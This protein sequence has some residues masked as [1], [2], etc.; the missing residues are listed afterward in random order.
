MRALL[1]LL[2]SIRHQNCLVL[3]PQAG[4][5]LEYVRSPELDFIYQRV[6]AADA[7]RGCFSE[8][9]TACGG[10]RVNV[11]AFS[12][13]WSQGCFPATSMKPAFHLCSV[14]PLQHWLLLMISWELSALHICMHAA[15]LSVLW[16]VKKKKKIKRQAKTTLRCAYTDTYIPKQG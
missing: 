8:G 10:G 6:T 3:W 12:W 1:R 15:S 13:S 16:P 7:L 5:C 11:I 9:E 4:R 14:L 2:F